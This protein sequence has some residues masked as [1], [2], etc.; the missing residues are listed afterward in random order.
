[1]AATWRLVI[2]YDGSAFSGWQRQP[3]DPSVQATLEAA[4]GTLFGVPRVITHASGRTDA[5]V[6]ALGQVVS[7]TAEK[8]RDPEHVRLGLNT[9]LPPEVSVIDAAL[10]PAGFHARLS[11][12]GKT[13]RYRVLHR[14]DRSPF[15]HRYAFQ[16]RVA[17][18]WAAIEQGMGALVGTHDFSAFRGAGCT[19][20][21]PVRTIDWARHRQDADEHFLEFHGN[22][23]L[24]YQVR[25]MVGTLIEVGT[26]KRAASSVAEVLSGRDPRAAGKTAL[27][28][29][30]YLVSVDYPAAALLLDAVAG[31][32]EPGGVAHGGGAAADAG[33]GDE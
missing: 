12:V 21:S 11:A 29:G 7:F 9:L 6:H 33:A 14:R 31:V 25:R 5:G 17:C 18:E 3:R 13:Y 15:H 23:F 30:L 16:L 4:L 32:Q 26:G 27:P 10:A 2:E 22:G 8:H 24:R 19:A 28:C 20:K 1:M